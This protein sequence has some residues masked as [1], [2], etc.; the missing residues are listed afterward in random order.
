MHRLVA[1]ALALALVTAACG[2][3]D[4]SGETSTTQSGTAATGLPFT[5]VGPDGVETVVEDASRI[6]SLSGEFSEIIWELGLG[7]NLVGV[8]LSSVYPPDEMR[9]LPKIGVERLLL[10]EP[11]LAQEPTV[12][13]GDEDATPREVIDQVRQAGVPV[14]IF[15]RFM[16]IDAPAAK[17]M[18]VGEVLGVVERAEELAARVQ[19]EIDTVVARSATVEVRPR[20]AVVYAA[21]RGETLL[22]LGDNT[23]MGGI[24]EAAGG[25]D[26]APP[27]GADGMMPLTP[28]ALAAG[29][30]E[31]IITSE[32]AFEA[33]GEMEGFTALPGVAQTPAGQNGRILVYEDLYL[34]G[35]GPRTGTLLAELFEAMHPDSAS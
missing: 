5:F 21:N 3:D 31:V 4:A 27:A 20:A 35:L 9:M 12:V 8:D 15:P 14:V 17:I 18:A 33:L 6:V 10:A 19:A 7:A 24:I 11:I 34:L 26:V 29:Q 2:G 30:P 13:I 1:V 23:V 32:R 25:I 16:G 28:E 22:L